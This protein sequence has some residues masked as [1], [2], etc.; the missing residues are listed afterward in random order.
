VLIRGEGIVTTA[1][2]SLRDAFIEDERVPLIVQSLIILVYK[3]IVAGGKFM[4]RA[5]FGEGLPSTR[6]G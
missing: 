1:K 6:T 3:V 5:S 4:K 2:D